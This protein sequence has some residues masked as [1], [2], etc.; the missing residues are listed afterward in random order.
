MSL[1]LPLFLSDKT[2]LPEVGGPDAFYFKNFEASH[3]RD[4]FTTGMDNFN[5]EQKNR[6]IER[7]KLFDWKKA[8]QEFLK[9][10]SRL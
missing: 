4:V 9:I 6:L 8:A 1:G 10:Y 7:S 2:S 3:M 5:P